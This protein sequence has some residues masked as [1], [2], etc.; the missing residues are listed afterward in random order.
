MDTM[1]SRWVLPAILLGI[2]AMAPRP[3]SAEVNNCIEINSLPAVI[4]TQGV[5]CLKKHLSTAL[6]TGAAITVNVN[7]V[8]INCNKFKIGNLA[9][10]P[11]TMASGIRAQGRINVVVAEC[12]IRGFQHGVELLDGD[13][14]V[15]DN[16]FD[17]NTMT[18]IRVSGDGSVIR[19][20]T[21]VDTGGTT[22]AGVSAYRGIHASGDLDVI[23][24]AVSN[25]VATAGDVTVEGIRTE[26]MGTG[27]IRGNRVRN[28]FASG[29]GTRRGIWNQDSARIVV[30]GNV[31][32]MPGG[33]LSS[34]VGIRCSGLTALLSPGIAR[35]N[36]I[37]GVSV[38]ANVLV[39]CNVGPDNHSSLL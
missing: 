16:R 39:G 25:V 5:Y 22:V 11:S 2:G 29:F 8:T 31:V 4:S 35:D 13:Y 27:V 3:A 12:G 37:G 6:S 1:S 7:N 33:L 34:D 26:N 38:L 17:N 9:A 14:A 30:E 21:I 20:N 28:I 15:E 23:D 18:G 32:T 24:N 36:T 19:G 10:G